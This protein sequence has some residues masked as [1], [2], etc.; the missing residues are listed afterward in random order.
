MG[1]GTRR[2]LWIV[3]LG[4]L[5]AGV[6]VTFIPQNGY[7][8]WNYART[9]STSHTEVASQPCAGSGVKGGVDYGALVPCGGEEYSVSETNLVSAPF[10]SDALALNPLP[11]AGLVVLG[12]AGVTSMAIAKFGR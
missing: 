12:V 11:L 5:A 8:L 2:V 1:V 6:L 3:G 7:S 10:S 4:L 9:E